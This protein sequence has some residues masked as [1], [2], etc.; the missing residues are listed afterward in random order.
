MKRPAA[1]DSRFV[2]AGRL[3]G[4]F[5]SPGP[6]V[7]PREIQFSSYAIRGQAADRLPPAGLKTPQTMSDLQFPTYE[8]IRVRPLIN[9]RRQ[10]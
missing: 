5:F 6:G 2:R 8:S 1:C 3:T 10:D 9:C 7:L 4:R